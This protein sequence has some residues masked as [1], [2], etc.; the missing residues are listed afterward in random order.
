MN[1]KLLKAEMAKNGMTQ[2]KL[3]EAIGMSPSTFIRKM[4][5]GVFNSDEIVEMIEVLH[6][7]DPISIFCSR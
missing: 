2:Q 4:K 7:S 3:C 6:I 1:R 5:K